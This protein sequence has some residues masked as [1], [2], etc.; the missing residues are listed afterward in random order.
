MLQNPA[1]TFPMV[2]AFVQ[3]SLNSLENENLVTTLPGFSLI[4]LWHTSLQ[5]ILR[6]ANSPFPWAVS[7]EMNEVENKIV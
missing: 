3:A 7:H 1:D 2:I 5:C 6:G 4:N